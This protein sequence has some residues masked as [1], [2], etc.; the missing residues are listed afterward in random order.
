MAGFTLVEILATVTVIGILAGIVLAA[1]GGVQ[2]KAARDQAKTE[3]KTMCV[4]ME[5]YKTDNGAFPRE[6]TSKTN[7]LYGYLTNYM[8]FRENQISRSG[9]NVFVVDPY[10]RAYYYVSPPTNR[11]RM[12]MDGFEIWSLGAKPNASDSNDDIGSWD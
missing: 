4:A 6:A 7:V 1:A 9:T 12:V 11:S 5:R 2:K 10:G 8:T 3:I